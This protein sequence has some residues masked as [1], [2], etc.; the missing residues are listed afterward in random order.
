MLEVWR[1]DDQ[2]WRE[3]DTWEG[4]VRVRAEPFEDVEIDLAQLWA[5]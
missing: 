4:D 2:K 5:R 3:V 1:L